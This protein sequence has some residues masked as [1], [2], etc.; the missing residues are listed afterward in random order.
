MPYGSGGGGSYRSRR[1]SGDWRVDILRRLNLPVTRNNLRLLW[2]WQRAEGG[3]SA[4]RHNWLNTTQN[5]P[6]ASS[7]NSA[8]VKRYRSYAQGI[9]ATVR[10][11]RYGNY[12]QIRSLMQANASPVRTA[13]AVG[14]SPWGTSGSLMVSVLRGDPGHGRSAAGGGR[15][16]YVNG[17]AG[18]TRGRIDQGVDFSGSGWIR[19][20]GRGI[21]TRADHGGT[22]WPGIGGMLVYH[23]TSGPLRGANIFIAE[24]VKLHVRVG[25]TIRAGQRIA[26]ATGGHTGIETGFSDRHGTP[27]DHSWYVNQADGTP[28]KHGKLFNRFL[29]QLGS[30]GGF[31]GGVPGGGGGTGP[32][33]VSSVT[34]PSGMQSVLGRPLSPDQYALTSAAMPGDA[35]MPDV[36]LDSPDYSQ[37]ADLWNQVSSGP[38]ASPDSR[39]MAQNASFLQRSQ[40]VGA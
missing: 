14:A 40:G 12:S 5:M 3:D 21:V 1:Y 30:G 35:T 36:S 11:L 15:G 18:L 28:T 26:F 4:Q 8:G 32:P 2:A 20:I 38:Y 33:P 17:Y 9:N 39:M 31:G 6:G 19:A 25:Q 13:R 24:D 7:I 27:L 29:D 22:G 37:L 23:L 16:P 34:G 10:T